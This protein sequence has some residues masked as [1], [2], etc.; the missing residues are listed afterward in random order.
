MRERAVV[1]FNV[2]GFRAAVTTVKDAALRGRPFVVSG[3][4]SGGRALVLDCSPEA[5]GEG[6]LPGMPLAAAMRALKGLEVLPPDLKSYE[7]MNNELERIAA[8]YAPVWENDKLGNLYFDLSG[9]TGIYGPIADATS[10]IMRLLTDETGLYPA[11]ASS[12]NKTV[13]KVATRMIRPQGLVHVRS[14]SEAEFL[15]RQDI[16][17]LPGMGQK[18]LRIAEATGIRE[19]G[20]VASLTEVEALSLFGRPGTALRNMA[21][22]IDNSPVEDKH[23]RHITKQANFNEDVIEEEV[24]KGALEALIEEAGFEMRK[25]RFGSSVVRF[26]IVYA[27]G[28]EAENSEKEKRLCVTDWDITA[29]AIRLYHKTA[30]RRIR[31]RSVALTLE[32]L[33]PLGYNTDLFEVEGEAKYRRLQ[34]ALDGIQNRYGAGSVNRGLVLVASSFQGGKKFLTTK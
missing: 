29:A 32:G 7:A 33:T 30:T 24:I 21:R 11:T 23:T 12:S 16:G 4:A 6:I 22:G 27:D 3:S 25:D 18:L 17:I 1:H 10:R 19:I 26:K 14:G 2:I 31:V 8:K 34:E 28:N 15:A 9:T 13:A 5:I 20:E